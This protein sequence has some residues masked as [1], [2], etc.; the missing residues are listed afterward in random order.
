MIIVLLGSMIVV[1]L[2][3]GICSGKSSVTKILENKF[4]AQ[5]ID[6]DKLGHEVRFHSII[7]FILLCI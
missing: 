5:V 6:A 2:T 7:T 4:Q 3:G 1:G